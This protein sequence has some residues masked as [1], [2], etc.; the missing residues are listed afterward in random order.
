MASLL[1]LKQRIK[2]AQNVSK[3]TRAMQMVAASKM[4][5]AQEATLATRPYVEKLTQINQNLLD[6]IE[7]KASHPY[8]AEKALT[9]KSLII[10]LSPDKG[11]CGGLITNLLREFLRNQKTDVNA[12]YIVVGK[13]AVAKVAHFTNEIIA[14]FD[15]GTTTPM[16]DMVHPLTK[17]ID[18]HY[19]GGSVDNVKLLYT[20]FNSIFTQTPRITTILPLTTS[21][22][23]DEEKMPKETPESEYLFEPPIEEILPELLKHY[24]EM[25][26]FQYILESFVSE[27]GA[28]M[29]SMQNATNNA[30]D[31]I[32]DLQLEYNKTRQSKIT[33]DILDLNSGGMSNAE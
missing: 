13:K 15:F 16:F 9:G 23:E 24:L 29:I 6:K 26:L 21:T 22:D 2:A 1:L 3:T 28:R 12:E 32:S 10:V 17:L 25:S 5:K 8:I 4:K 27:Q 18:E 31:I 33:S 30:N 11:L 20:N 14:S 19:L 7:N